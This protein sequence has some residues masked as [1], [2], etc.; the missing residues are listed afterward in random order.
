MLSQSPNRIISATNISC[1]IIPAF[2][3]IDTIHVVP[4]LRLERRFHA[5]EACCLP[6]ADPGVFAYIRVQ[7][8]VYSCILNF[9]IFPDGDGTGNYCQ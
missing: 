1:P 9:Q 6:L 5:P 8:R 4:G 2:N 3:Y 7:I